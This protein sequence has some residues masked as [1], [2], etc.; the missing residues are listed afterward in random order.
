MI[1]L[2]LV[3]PL[4]VTAQVSIEPSSAPGDQ[5]ALVGSSATFAVVATGAP[6]LFYQWRYYSSS[7]AFTNIPGA[8]NDTLIL[9]NVQPVKGFFAV[10]VTNSGG[11]VV[12]R[13]AKL[14]ITSNSRVSFT[15]AVWSTPESFIT[16]PLTLRRDVTL[17]GEISVD[18]STFD[19]SAKSGSQYGAQSG[20][21]TF[22]P[23]ETNKIIRI[24]I[25]NDAIVDSPRT[26]RVT[27]SNPS[28]GVL[29]VSPTTATV[30]VMNT[31]HGMMF[32]FLTNSVS[33]DAGEATISVVRGDDLFVPATVDV[34]TSDGTARAGIDYVGVTN[35]LS[36]GPLERTKRFSVAILNNLVKQPNRTFRIKLANPTGVSLWQPSAT[37]V[38]TIADNDQGFQFDSTRYSVRQDTGLLFLDVRRGTDDTA[39]AAAVDVKTRPGSAVEDVDYLPIT[40]RVTFAPGEL[41]KR[42]GVRILNSGLHGGSRT[43]TVA[44]TSPS[45]GTNLGQPNSVPVTILN[46]NPGLGFFAANLTNAWGESS[47]FMVTVQRGHGVKLDPVAVNYSTLNGTAQAGLDYTAVSGTLQFGSNETVKAIPIPLLKDRAAHGAKSFRVVL[48]QPT[49]GVPLGLAATTVFIEGLYARVAAPFDTRLQVKGTQG[50]VQVSWDG[51]GALQRADCLDGPWEIVAPATNTITLASM[52]G[53]SFYRASRPFPTEL[54]VPSRY[55]GSKP[56]PLVILLHGWT[57]TG[58][59]QEEYM[60]LEPLA[61]SQGFFYCH[62]ESELD[63]QGYPS[64]IHFLDESDLF[65]TGA[66]DSARLR[67]LVEE[68]TSHFAV[69]RKRVYFIGHS[70]G[71][72]MA[73]R[74]ASAASDLIAGVASFAGETGLDRERYRPSQ[75]VNLLVIAGTADPSMAGGPYNFVEEGDPGNTSCVP[76]LYMM[77]DIWADYNYASDPVTDLAPTLDLTTDVS[78]L[79]TIVTRYTHAKPGGALELWNIQGGAH[80]PTLSSTFSSRI[81]DWLFA[82][83]KP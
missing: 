80:V 26:F 82:H 1:G 37:T 29:L 69:D 41:V 77:L 79:D 42:V 27:L 71:G 64:W 67:G 10:A 35:T 48:S 21:L 62:P 5:L 70:M 56:M 34:V 51:G 13:Q 78:G 7:I 66:D 38:V 23:G 54:Y 32:R 68:I 74:M 75:P 47:N 43:F 6:P 83:P 4:R 72:G 60:H 24:P 46:S 16:V 39:T 58:A 52:G 63:S 19:E 22:G 73:C 65:E 9:T 53:R 14:T 57:K 28:V 50:L 81:I 25:I 44:L 45:E 2:F 36:F 31:D 61:E 40:N 3:A 55:D 8:T 20:T 76:S 59:W 49:D 15:S 33:E 30:T 17:D 12:S 11:G 18:Y